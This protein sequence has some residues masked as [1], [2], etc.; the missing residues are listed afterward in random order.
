M[1]K[2]SIHTL[3]KLF[4]ADRSKARTLRRALL[5]ARDGWLP[6]HYAIDK[7]LDL[8]NELLEAHG[9]EAIHSG[10]V[11]DG[12]Y[13]DIACLYV[14]RGDTYDTTLLYDTARGIFLVQSYGDWIERAE[15]RGV[16]VI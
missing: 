4:D 11:W 1:R 6:D 12:Y 15:R 3:R 9:V 7:A 10:S 13:C 8:A 14:N 16:E 5:H 2:P